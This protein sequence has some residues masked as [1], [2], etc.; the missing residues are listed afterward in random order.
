MFDPDSHCFTETFTLTKSSQP[1]KYNRWIIWM[2]WISR[3]LV[4]AKWH[5][6]AVSSRNRSM[7]RTHILRIQSEQ[8]LP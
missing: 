6:A 2:M 7:A 4:R 5:Q 8:S 3:Y 1:L